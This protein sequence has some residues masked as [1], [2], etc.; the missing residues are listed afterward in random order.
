MKTLV[1]DPLEQFPS[2]RQ[3]VKSDN[4]NNGGHKNNNPNTGHGHVYPRPDGVRARCGGPMVCLTCKQDRDRLLKS[5]V[6]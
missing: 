3:R 2:G 5:Q 6:K 4:L 1:A